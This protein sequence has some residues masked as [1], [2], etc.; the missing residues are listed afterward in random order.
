MI[1]W[2]SLG[3]ALICIDM[4]QITY[5]HT[6]K[7]MRLNNVECNCNALKLYEW[8]AV[9]MVISVDSQMTHFSSFN[10]SQTFILLLF[11]VIDHFIHY[12][13]VY[14]LKKSL[15]SIQSPVICKNISDT[16]FH[17]DI[18]CYF[19]RYLRRRYFVR[20]CLAQLVPFIS[21]KSNY[22]ITDMLALSK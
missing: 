14:I 5:I 3:N 12:C 11:F 15:T 10:P 17:G 18:Y 13:L 8:V 2:I 1:C 20:Q 7:L 21:A 16:S 4:Y 9:E 6:F 19:W 22:S